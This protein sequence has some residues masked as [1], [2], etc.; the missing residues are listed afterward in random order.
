MHQKAIRQRFGGN[1]IGCAF[2]DE[3]FTEGEEGNMRQQNW[4][5]LHMNGPTGSGYIA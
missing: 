1:F 2:V 3:T 5:A 4:M